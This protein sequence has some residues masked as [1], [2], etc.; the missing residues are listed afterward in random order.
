MI[1][2]FIIRK[3]KELTL[4]RVPDFAIGPADDPYMLRWWWLPRNRFFNVYVH[5]M[6]HDDDDRALH[7]HPWPS[8]SLCCAGV[9]QEFYTSP[10]GAYPRN[11]LIRKGDWVYRRAKFAHRLAVKP[12]EELPMTIFITGPRIREWGF[13]CPKGWRH[14]MDFVS[15]EGKGQVGRGCGEMD[16]P[17]KAPKRRRGFFK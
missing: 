12:A 14:W 1:K 16:G 6:R 15:S 8:L 9:L 5:I 11:R 13:H 7:D 3:A 10:N 4:S 17:S 2:S